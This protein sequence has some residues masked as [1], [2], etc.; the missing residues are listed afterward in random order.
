MKREGG[1]LIEIDP[2]ETGLTPLC[3]VSIRGKAGETLHQLAAYI[4]AK[5]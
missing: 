4:R 5:L 3:D 1:I 2:Y